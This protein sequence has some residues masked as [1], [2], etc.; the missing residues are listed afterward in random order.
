MNK[1]YNKIV[2]EISDSKREIL[3]V[4]VTKNVDADST[5]EII[6]DGVLAIGENRIEAFE[7]KAS[8]ILPV[9]KHFIG[10]IQSRKIKKIVKL[11]DCLESVASI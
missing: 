8:S 10:R 9:E 1:I 3:L 7:R 11:F 6:R 2:Q 4:A 5:N